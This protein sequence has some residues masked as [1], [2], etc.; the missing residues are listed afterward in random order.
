MRI[1]LCSPY[2]TSDLSGVTTFIATLNAALRERDHSVGLYAPDSM[3]GISKVPPG[4][5]N[6]SLAARTFAALLGARPWTTIHASQP[7][8]QS[9]AALLA[10]RI[11]GVGYVVTY[12]SVLPAAGGRIPALVLRL[13]DW[14]LC[15]FARRRVFVSEATRAQ[16][17]R[18]GDDVIYVGVDTKLADS[19]LVSADARADPLISFVFLGRQ[20]E[21]KGFF[22]LLEVAEDIATHGGASFRLLLIG[23][24]PA[25]ERSKRADWLK[26]LVGVVAD[27]GRI[28]SRRDLFRALASADAI[29]LPSRREGLP[30]VL[31]EAMAVGCVPI[32]TDVGG[33]KE[34]VRPGMTG[35]I[36]PPENAAALKGAMLWAS[37]N[38]SD[39]RAMGDRAVLD[40]RRRFSIRSMVDAYLRTYTET[41]C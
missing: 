32:A 13:S 6:L 3:G 14:I 7:H 9:V 26:R 1:A 34:L 30:L 22:E 20:T 27:L 38:L 15:R 33:V 12:H 29:V 28:D 37:N 25:E 18:A 23:D 10:A 36:V 5:H 31:V 21:S 16:L 8:L 17:G 41:N 35:I 2:N 11:L 40:I 4:L 19:V 24:S 39:L